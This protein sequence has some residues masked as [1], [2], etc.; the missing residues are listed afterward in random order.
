VER[1]EINGERGDRVQG[2]EKEEA[3]GEGE[4]DTVGL[5][6]LEDVGSVAGQVVLVLAD[7]RR[8]LLAIIASLNQIYEEK[9]TECEEEG[10]GGLSVPGK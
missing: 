4:G 5:G 3:E 7:L 8:F 6:L 1:N 2:G 10:E 9:K